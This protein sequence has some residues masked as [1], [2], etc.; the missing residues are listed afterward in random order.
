MDVL[1]SSHQDK[2]RQISW[3]ELPGY[4][5]HTSY[6]EKNATKLGQI[7]QDLLMQKITVLSIKWSIK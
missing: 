2:M 6:F 7:T 1:L 4:I 3:A 5:N